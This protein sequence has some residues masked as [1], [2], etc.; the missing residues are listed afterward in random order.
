MF[1]GEI[2]IT[3]SKGTHSKATAVLLLLLVGL[4]S[5]GWSVGCRAC[6]QLI[7]WLFV[8]YCCLLLLLLLLLLGNGRNTVSRALLR[9]R[10]LAEFR[11]KLGEFALARR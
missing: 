3:S 10:D 5:V 9:K 8:V 6:G 1:D 11:V 2:Q 4:W 7:G